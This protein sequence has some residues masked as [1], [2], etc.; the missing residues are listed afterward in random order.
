MSNT[1]VNNRY[2]C[3][4]LGPQEYAVPLLSIKEVIGMPEITAVP[5]SPKHFLGIMNLRGN[6]ISVVDLRAK[7]GLKPTNSEETAVMIFDLG[8]FFLGVVVDKINSVVSIHPTE[9]SD[10]PMMESIASTEYIQ[11]VY[12]NKDR[13]VL[14]ISIEKALSL[15]EKNIFINNSAKA[16]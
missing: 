7:I 11:N 2:I 13:L 3:F 10:K 1:D 9:I 12:R 14:L 16:A 8:N 6:V 4:N 15:D 5:Q